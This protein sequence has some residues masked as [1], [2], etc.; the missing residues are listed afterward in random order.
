M[1]RGKYMINDRLIKFFKEKNWWYEYESECYKKA[2]KNLNIDMNS[3]F[4]SFYLHVEDS[5]TFSSKNGEIYQLGWFL[6]NTD[7]RNHIF[8]INDILN[9]SH[10]FI[11]LNSF[12]SENGFFFNTIDGS[13]IS[14]ILGDDINNPKNTWGDFNTFLIWFFDL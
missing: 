12:E 4:I 8:N 5:T 10:H 11:L 1:L 6:S 13:V 2:L 3:D 9:I 7:L 14:Y